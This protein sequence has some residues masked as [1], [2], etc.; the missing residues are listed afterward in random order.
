MGQNLRSPRT[1]PEQAFRS[2]GTAAQRSPLKHASRHC[3][4]LPHGT[5]VARDAIVRLIKNKLIVELLFMVS[6]NQIEILNK[7]IG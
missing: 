6:V 4:E 3:F 2:L 1:S 7:L 5:M